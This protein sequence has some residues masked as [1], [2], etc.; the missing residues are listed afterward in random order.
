MK[1]V[2]TTMLALLAVTTSALAK[3][4]Y[5]APN[6]D[7]KNVGT[8]KSPFKTIAKATAVMQAGDVC[9]LREGSYPEVLKSARSG[10]KKKPITYRSYEGEQ[11]WIDAAETVDGW[12]KHEGN[13]YKVKKALKAS[14]PIYNTLFVDDK[15]QN[16]ARW[17]ND[18]DNDPYTFE[19]HRIK[20]GSAGHFEVEG[21]PE[22][23]LTG[24]YFCYMGA[25]SGTTWS[26]KINSHSGKEIHFDAVDIKKWPYNPH[27]PT[28]FR[29]K[30]RGQLYVYGKIELL[31]HPG[32]WF[33]DARTQTI[34]AIFPDGKAPKKGSVKVGVRKTTAEI[35]HDHI[36]LDGVGCYGGE[37]RIMGSNVTLKNGIY[38]NCSQTLE[39]LIGISAQSNT[40]SIAVR[41]GDVTIER[42]LIEG[43]LA[44]GISI[45][46]KDDAQNYTIHNN[47]IRYFDAIGIHANP[48]R[49]RGKYTKI[50]NNSI[51]TCGRDGVST[52]G[53]G[54]EIAYNDIYDCMRT[55][56]DGG[57][58]YTVGNKDLKNTEIHHNYVHDSYGPAY[59]DGRAAGI[60]LDN[61][62]KGYLV[63]HN[64]VWNVTWSALMFNWYNVNL[65]FY[66][67]TIW[68]CG[69]NTGR[70]A[71]GYEMEKIVLKNNYANVTSREKG[72]GKSDNDWIGTDFEANMLFKES[73][74][75]SAEKRDF[76]LPAGSPL[77]DKGVVI[78]GFDNKFSGKSPDV[79][80]YEFGEKLWN[81]GASWASEVKELYKTQAQSM[82]DV[83]KIES[84]D[85]IF[86]NKKK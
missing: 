9:V 66:N 28:V 76:T 49:S 12:V 13:I 85:Q 46:P 7:D 45:S 78:K 70:W 37:V 54:T 64:V 6:G 32:E 43:G 86:H 73:P 82:R 35:N 20:G 60:Y 68:D 38:R 58:Y 27:N 30:N 50:T 21:L 31:D 52:S 40:A 57:V 39:G 8:I 71:N 77:I 61:N 2:L 84:E 69:F 55:N 56:N 29:N 44:T 16:I 17:P 80:A 41:G 34:Y 74:F 59:A 72:E 26:R 48:V 23:N 36:I 53:Y 51:Y 47:V 33:Y 75:T 5:V 62:S 19:A 15:L 63:H 4:Y 24:G 3:E 11:A 10:S 18:S 83:T 14:Q 67:N 22:V 81:V 65:L 79:G 1:R 25:H 42:N